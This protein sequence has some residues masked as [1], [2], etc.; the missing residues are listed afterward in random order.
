MTQAHAFKAAELCV[1]AQCWRTP[2]HNGR[3]HDN[4]NAAIIGAGRFTAAM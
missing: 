1:K 3:R 4:L 2:A